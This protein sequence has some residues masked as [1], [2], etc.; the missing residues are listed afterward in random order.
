MEK[1]CP[2]RKVSKVSKSDKK[3]IKLLGS[4]ILILKT[5]KENMPIGLK[6][7]TIIKITKL[8]EKTIYRRLGRLKNLNIVCQKYPLWK[9]C[10]SISRL[11]VLN[12]DINQS[13]SYIIN[14]KSIINV[15]KDECYFCGYNQVLDEHHI[16]PKELGG[17]SNPCNIITLCPNCHTSIHRLR[18]KL[19]LIDKSWFA[20]NKDSNL[21][22]L[23]EG[24]NEKT[25]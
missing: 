24:R 2:M 19:K 6:V 10:D 9:I 21:I 8:S 25:V 20:F 4:D 1:K 14:K 18:L 23:R 11:F 3:E 12:D 5:I 13:T 22:L 16:V 7:Q 15:R 17:D